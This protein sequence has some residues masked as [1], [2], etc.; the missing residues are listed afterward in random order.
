MLVIM[1]S[2]IAAGSAV[3][4]TRMH[5]GVVG[6]RTLHSRQDE[7]GQSIA[8]SDADDQLVTDRNLPRWL[9]LEID[10]GARRVVAFFDRGAWI[11]WP[12]HGEFQLIRGLAGSR[13]LNAESVLLVQRAPHLPARDLCDLV[14]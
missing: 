5:H 2:C 10:S 3:G 12:R 9:A 6:P 1:C 14:R 4:R 11:G 13:E 8:V 7:G